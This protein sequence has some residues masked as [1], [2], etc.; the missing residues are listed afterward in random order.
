[1][2]VT[3]ADPFDYSRENG[4]GGASGQDTMDQ[5]TTKLLMI[6]ISFLIVILAS[7]FQRTSD[8]D[9]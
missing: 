5:A 2:N 6:P 3:E 9:I 8:T 1:M 4:S 7:N